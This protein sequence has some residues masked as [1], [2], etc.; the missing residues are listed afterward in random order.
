M[1]FASREQQMKALDD[2]YQSWL[3]KADAYREMGNDVDFSKTMFAKDFN[4]LDE[5]MDHIV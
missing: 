3:I 2:Y 4:N 5:F 1:N